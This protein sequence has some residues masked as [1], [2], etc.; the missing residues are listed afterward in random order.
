MLVSPGWALEPAACQ[1]DAGADST[2][3]RQVQRSTGYSAG[4]YGP[5]CHVP[6]HYRRDLQ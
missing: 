1:R 3:C 6:I 2:T 4:Y 5:H